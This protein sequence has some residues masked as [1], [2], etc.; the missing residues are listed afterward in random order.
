MAH[1]SWFIASLP[2]LLLYMLL[3]YAQHDLQAQFVEKIIL[4]DGLRDAMSTKHSCMVQAG[5]FPLHVIDSLI[6]VREYE[7]WFDWYDLLVDPTYAGQGRQYD[8]HVK[9]VLVVAEA[10]DTVRLNSRSMVIDSVHINGAP[11]T[12]KVST[13]STIITRAPGFAPPKRTWWMCGMHRYSGGEDSMLTVHRRLTHLVRYQRIWCTRFLNPTMLLS[14]SHVTTCHM[15]R[16]CS[17]CMHGCL[18]VIR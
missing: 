2:S 15:T 8:G 12:F 5:E 16:H 1:R 14:G 13:T 6:D 11:T 4:D 17:P 3:C 10:T 18:T 9:I 7:L